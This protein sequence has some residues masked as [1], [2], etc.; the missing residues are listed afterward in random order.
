MFPN[1]YPESDDE[2]DLDEVDAIRRSLIKETM[3]ERKRRGWLAHQS[4][5]PPSSSSS[6]SSTSD[7]RT[8]EGSVGEADDNGLE[9][10][11]LDTHPL[12]TLPSRLHVY[13][14]RFG[15]WEGEGLR[16]YKGKGS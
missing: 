12:S 7:K 11:L 10:P 5:F 6:S 8:E 16:K 15:H 9:E 1:P 2:L 13:R 4:V 14:G 3:S